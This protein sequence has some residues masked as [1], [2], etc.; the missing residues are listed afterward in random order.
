MFIVACK[1]TSKQASGRWKY[2]GDMVAS[3]TIQSLK[4]QLSA[5]NCCMVVTLLVVTICQHK[6]DSATP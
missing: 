5:R 6:Q 2:T 1:D 4:E 3:S